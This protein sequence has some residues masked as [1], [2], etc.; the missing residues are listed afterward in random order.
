M[1]LTTPDQLSSNRVPDPLHASVRGSGRA[2]TRVG[3]AKMKAAALHAPALTAA[4]RKTALRRRPAAVRGGVGRAKTKAAAVQAPA[5]TA[6]QRKTAAEDTGALRRRPAAVRG[7][8]G[9]AKTKA[10]A[11]QASACTAARRKPVLVRVPGIDALKRYP[12]VV[13]GG[14]RPTQTEATAVNARRRCLVT[15]PNKRHATLF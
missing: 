10:A 11:V 3:R 2:G 5:L 7:G 14:V 4:Q 13:H 9:R 6:A 12:A 8:V 1:R 15:G